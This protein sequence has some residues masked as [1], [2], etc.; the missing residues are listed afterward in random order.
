M[1]G[2]VT[3]SL[4]RATLLPPTFA[5]KELEGVEVAGGGLDLVDARDHGLLEDGVLRDRRVLARDPED[6]PVEREEELLLDARGDLGAG[7]AGLR[8]LVDDHHLRRL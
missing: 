2:T 1:G 3:P 4:P 7:A 5:G 6:R 8:R